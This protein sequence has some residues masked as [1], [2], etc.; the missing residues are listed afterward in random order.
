MIALLLHPSAQLSWSNFT[1]HPS[2][3]IGIAA[4]G[5]AYIWRVRQGP[6]ALDR[7]PVTVP[8][9]A[10]ATHPQLEAAAAPPG[11]TSG[12]RL[13]FVAS[14]LLLFLTLNG[15]LHDLSDFYLF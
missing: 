12:Q 6:S 11:P 10:Q 3:A 8:D 13:S 1:V 15:P 14:L 7:V 2:T 5:A 4:I 9:M